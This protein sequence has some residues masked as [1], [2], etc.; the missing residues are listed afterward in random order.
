M[1][2][3]PE[4]LR[5]IGQKFG[6]EQAEEVTNMLDRYDSLTREEIE[7]IRMQVFARTMVFFTAVY[8]AV[9]SHRNNDPLSIM[10]IKQGVLL[11]AGYGFNRL[12]QSIRDAVTNDLRQVFANIEQRIPDEK[13]LVVK[14]ALDE[15]N[16]TNRDTQESPG[17][18]AARGV[19][20]VLQEAVEKLA[21]FIAGFFG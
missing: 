21:P 8:L 1:L 6:A 19:R 16:I 2:R 18:S 11:A 9:S 12:M 14:A 15:A 7:K 3:T 4:D 5:A 20:T 13:R 10:L 17:E